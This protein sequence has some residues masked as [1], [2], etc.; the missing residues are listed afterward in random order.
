M[1][2][3][4]YKVL[5]QS[6]HWNIIKNNNINERKVIKL[7]KN[8]KGTFYEE[9]EPNVYDTKFYIRRIVFVS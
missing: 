7:G 5:K 1:K 3:A 4:E 2:F 6:F 9:I 8:K